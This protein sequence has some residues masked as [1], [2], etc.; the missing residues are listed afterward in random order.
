MMDNKTANFILGGSFIL[1]ALIFGIF[2]Y[3]AQAKPNV[4]RVVGSAT[5]SVESDIV[6]WR[7][8]LSRNTGLNNVETGYNLL[9]GDISSLKKL[10]KE[11][12]FPEKD[13]GLQPV[14]SMALY[15]SNG[16]N[17]TG[18]QLSQGV[19]L[20]SGNINAVE[21]LALNPTPLFERGVIVQS[22]TLEYYLSRLPDIKK[23]LLAEAIRDAAARA[24]S[25]AKSANS[26]LGKLISAKVGVFQITEP[27][28]TETQNYGTYNTTTR[29][30]DITVTITTE[31][32]LN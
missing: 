30:K 27:Y 18:Y 17:V 21:E 1:A 7:I 16:G 24:Q 3:S 31:F 14:N 11:K 20:I 23:D 2:F 32:G 8:T 29:Q 12:G 5:K 13:I 26:G 28:S 6:K 9:D 25:L 4:L 19:Y 22:S 10:L 15:Q